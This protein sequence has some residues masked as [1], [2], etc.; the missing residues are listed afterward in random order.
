MPLHIAVNSYTDHKLFEK[1]LLLLI[2]GG[3]DLNLR[4]FTS[5]ETPLFR[6][7]G[8][9][10]HNLKNIGCYWGLSSEVTPRMV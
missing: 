7:V 8:E 1:V 10:Q 6:A 4:A 2:Q 9:G 3:A 5:L